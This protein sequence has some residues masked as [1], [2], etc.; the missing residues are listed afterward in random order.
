MHACRLQPTN[1]IHAFAKANP[2]FPTP[3]SQLSAQMPHIAHQAVQERNGI[4]DESVGRRKVGLLLRIGKRDAWNF[5][6]DLDR[7]L[8]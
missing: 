6:A 7:I 5:L 8:S 4:H 1:L 3:H 2:I